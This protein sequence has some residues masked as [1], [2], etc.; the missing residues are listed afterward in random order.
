MRFPLVAKLARRMLCITTTSAPSERLFSQAGLTI[1]RDRARLDP[2]FAASLIFL[3]DAWDIAERYLDQNMQEMRSRNTCWIMRCARSIT[4]I[5]TLKISC[6]SQKNLLRRQRVTTIQ[7]D[8]LW[9]LP[10]QQLLSSAFLHYSNTVAA[11]RL[12]LCIL[13]LL[14]LT[15]LN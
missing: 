15:S 12:R 9:W 3:Q 1:A 2:D 14:H 4:V 7:E 10:Q 5:F 13:C 11:M 8:C 6:C